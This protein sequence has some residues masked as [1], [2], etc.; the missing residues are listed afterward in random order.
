MVH[1]ILCHPFSLSLDFSLLLHPT[2][3]LPAH[4]SRPG[5]LCTPSFCLL[6]LKRRGKNLQS[7]QGPVQPY[8]RATGCSWAWG[9]ERAAW[10]ANQSWAGVA[11]QQGANMGADA[12]CGVESGN[13]RHSI[14]LVGAGVQPGHRL[15]GT[16]GGRSR[17]A[18]AQADGPLAAAVRERAATPNTMPTRHAQPATSYQKS[19]DADGFCGQR[20]KARR[21]FG[22]EPGRP[23]QGCERHSWKAAGSAPDGAP[24]A[25]GVAPGATITLAG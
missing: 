4:L 16:P 8:R 13:K 20:G 19:L 15:G 6:C 22:E 18:S 1:G 24:A 11:R 5:S 2:A 25:G 17:L 9:G 3:C 12:S 7:Q 21:G 23:Q 10:Q 14:R